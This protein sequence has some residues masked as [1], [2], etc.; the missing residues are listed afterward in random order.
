M[1]RFPEE[2][3]Y[4]VVLL[5]PSQTY[6]DVS[7]HHRDVK[8]TAGVFGLDDTVLRALKATK[9]QQL[10]SK[11]VTRLTQKRIAEWHRMAP[12]PWI[13]DPM[14]NSNGLFAGFFSPDADGFIDR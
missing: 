5:V 6:K 11:T 3:E 13:E 1:P 14:R 4:T 8:D 10:F 2:P 7:F 9:S 12:Q